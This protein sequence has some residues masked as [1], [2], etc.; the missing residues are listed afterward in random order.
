MASWQNKNKQTAGTINSVDFWVHTFLYD[1]IHRGKGRV[2][3]S[4]QKKQNKQYIL[5]R[6]DKRI[7]EAKTRELKSVVP[8][9]TPLCVA[10][11]VT[12]GG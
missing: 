1:A 2:A 4:W 5:C 7:K 9:L 11:Q 12:A 6:L 10:H 8:Q 3:H